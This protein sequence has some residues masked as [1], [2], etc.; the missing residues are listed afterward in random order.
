MNTA[1]A[2]A[3]LHAV[4]AVLPDG[5]RVRVTDPLSWDRAV[6]EWT[7]ADDARRAHRFGDVLHFCVRSMD[8]PDWNESPVSLGHATPYIPSR[9]F[10]NPEDAARKAWLLWQGEKTPHGTAQGTGGWFYWH[11]GRT[12][13]Q[14]LEDLAKLAI[15]RKLIVQGGSGRWYP[16]V[17]EL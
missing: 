16:A 13:C 11:N 2:T 8:D 5:S 1:T 15:A 7:K 9:G 6:A 3:E 14:G 12:A 17:S 10:K 4:F